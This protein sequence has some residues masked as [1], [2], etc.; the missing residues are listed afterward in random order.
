MFDRDITGHTEKS[1]HGRTTADVVALL[2]SIEEQGASVG[3]AMNLLS[4]SPSR[5]DRILVALH[6]ALYG[7]KIDS[8]ITCRVCNNKFDLDFDLKDLERAV[9]ETAAEPVN[10]YYETPDGFIYRPLKLA[11][12][13]CLEQ[14]DQAEVPDV[15]LSRILIKP[16]FTEIKDNPNLK[17]SIKESI[18]AHLSVLSPLI[19]TDITATCAEC[20]ASQDVHFD[21]QRF[22][23]QRLLNDK[24]WLMQEIHTIAAAYSWS[25]ESILSLFRSERKEL[26]EIIEDSRRKRKLK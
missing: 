1:I 15:L 25:L 2:Q 21:I 14:I 26:V 4:S 13:L 7:K 23:M 22:F 3:D 20:G 12:E 5:R 11:D 10:E 9:Y 18:E 8:N 17:R 24:R 6:T 19:D 16:A